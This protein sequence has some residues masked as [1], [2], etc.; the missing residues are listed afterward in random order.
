MFLVQLLL[1]VEPG[2]VPTVAYLVMT[3]EALVLVN[4]IEES[5]WS[6]SISDQILVLSAAK[7]RSQDFPV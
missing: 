3:C 7:Q 4:S 6:G 5:A 2:K 1:R